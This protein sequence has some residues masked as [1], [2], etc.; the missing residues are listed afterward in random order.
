MTEAADPSNMEHAA[1]PLARSDR[2]AITRPVAA[3]AEADDPPEAI[4]DNAGGGS[5]STRGEFSRLSKP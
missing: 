5:R 3:L 2:T 4:W 1:D